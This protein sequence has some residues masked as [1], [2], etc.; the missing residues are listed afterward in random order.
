MYQTEERKYPKA[1]QMEEYLAKRK[2]SRKNQQVRTSDELKCL[3]LQIHHFF[4]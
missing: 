2:R 4:L 1:I 3:I